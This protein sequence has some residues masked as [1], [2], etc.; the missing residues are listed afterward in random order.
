MPVLH[1][2]TRSI[3]AYVIPSIKIFYVQFIA[4]LGSEARRVR[5]YTMDARLS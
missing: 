1:Q 4:V 5:F 3:N 2:R